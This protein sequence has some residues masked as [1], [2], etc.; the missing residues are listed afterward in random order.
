MSNLASFSVINQKVAKIFR[1]ESIE[2]KGMAFVRF[3]LRT[4]LSLNDDEIEE[5]ITDGPM[6]GEIDAIYVSDRII[7]IMTFKYTDRFELSKKNYPESELDQ[8]ILTVDSIISGNLDKKTVN[9]AVWE[10]YQEILSLSSNGKIEF[11]IYVISNKNHPV[12]HAKR[13]LE[14]AIEKY[15]IVD[16]PLYFDQEDI[17]AKIL[18]N[19]TRKANGQIRFIERQHFEKANGNIKTVIGA[20]AATDLIELIKDKNNSEIINEQVFNENV[21]IYKPTHRVNKAI[22]DSAI[23]TDNYYFFYLNNGITILCDRA[24]YAPSTRSPVVNLTNF[25]IIN[26]GQT[27]HSLFE[28]HKTTPDKLESIELLVRVCEANSEDPISQK[29][30]ETS[31][32]QIPIGSRDL[33]SN[34]LIQRKLEEEFETLGYFYERKPNQHSEQSKNKV[35][36]NEILGQLFMAYHLDMPS[37]AKNSKSKVFSELYDLIFDEN[38]LNASELLRLY[39][40]YLP[41]L[42]R[43]KEIQRKKRRKEQFDEKEA[44][45]S[46]A[47]FHILNGI[48]YLFEMEERNIDLEDIP[49]NEKQKRKQKL[50]DTKG[51]EFT[52]RSINMIFEVVEIEM[53]TRG[54]VYTHDKFF[55]E[56]PTN[57]IIRI[58]IL[59][60]IGK[61]P[62]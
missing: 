37:E 29:I 7:H 47:T 62:H 12:D 18:E 17:V 41:L 23:E 45:I 5:T 51:P 36:N 40:L 26:G 30:S 14:N 44:F 25:Q 46:R 56:I 4:L 6:D 10:K 43:K 15:R 9:D 22:I 34:D 49:V 39:K 61:E 28:V 20:V 13:K 21:R 52:K 33:H 11:K 42:E 53:K 32:N 38:I 1:E 24:D 48:K 55:K 27:S 19:K 2:S 57:N 8:F 35:L 16:K 58:H 59:E 3:C 54:E 31:N 60:M 50:Y